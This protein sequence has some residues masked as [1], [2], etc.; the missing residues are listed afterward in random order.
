M[1]GLCH[2]TQYNKILVT[3]GRSS[4]NDQ[5]YCPSRIDSQ[6]QLAGGPIRSPLWCYFGHHESGLRCS[7]NNYNNTTTSPV[8]QWSDI[9]PPKRGWGD[10]DCPQLLQPPNSTKSWDDAVLPA[11]AEWLF[12]NVSTLVI[13]EAE[14]QLL[15]EA[16]SNF[17]QSTQAIM[18]RTGAAV[19]DKTPLPFYKPSPSQ[20]ITV[21]IRWGD[22]IREMKDKK[23]IPMETYID[24][25]KSLLTPDELNGRQIVFIYL[26]TED[27]QAI[28][29]FQQDAPD[30]WSIHTSG[31]TNSRPK[32][33]MLKAAAQSN[34]LAGLESLAALLISMEANRFVLTGA[35]NW[36]RL[37]NELRKSVVDSRCGN[38]TR[39]IDV[40]PIPSNREAPWI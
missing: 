39:A 21:H 11:A 18:E 17:T 19:G 31:P 38:C 24:A 27:P 3:T 33:T 5:Q 13:H 20:L 26:A 29:E 40:A 8:V 35:S 6:H 14:R 32:M 15:M 34:G 10:Y 36:S 16:F 2:A 30:H 7:Y 4:W 37:M 1:A 22:K 23:L 9:P 25:A 12:Q 28:R